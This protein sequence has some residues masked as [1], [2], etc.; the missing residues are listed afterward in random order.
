LQLLIAEDSEDGRGGGVIRYFG[1]TGI[2][3]S[4]REV[5]FSQCIQTFK[6]VDLSSKFWQIFDSVHFDLIY[7][8]P[9]QF[10][11]RSRKNPG[12]SYARSENLSTELGRSACIMQYS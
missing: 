7:P 10:L 8:V 9:V 1:D 4:V 12:T 11:F 2:E 6:Y 5:N 3:F